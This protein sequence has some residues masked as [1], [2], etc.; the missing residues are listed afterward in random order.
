M[1]VPGSTDPLQSQP[2]DPSQTVVDDIR[3]ALRRFQILAYIVGT[4]LMLL[5]FV[6]VPLQYGARLPLVAEILGPV[7]GTLYI[8]YLIVAVDLSRRADL[9]MRQLAMIVVAGFIPVTTFIVERKITSQVERDLSSL[10]AP[11][12]TGTA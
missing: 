4:M 9:K 8:I 7:H 5:A 6:A 3:K 11:Q 1:T 12:Q 2:V 10:Q